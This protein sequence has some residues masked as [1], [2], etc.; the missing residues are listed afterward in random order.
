MM[1]ALTTV[2]VRCPGCSRFLLEASEYGRGVCPE[3][4][5]EVTV[6]S[7]EVRKRVDTFAKPGG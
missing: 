1:A 2:E 6:R 5:W 3:C 7:K 4:G